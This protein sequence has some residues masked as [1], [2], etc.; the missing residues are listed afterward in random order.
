[1]IDISIVIVNYNVQHYLRQTLLS[2]RAAAGAL[3]LECFVVDNASSDDSVAMLKQAFPELNLIA[4]KENLGFSKGNNL[5]L[6][7]AKGKYILLLNP[8]TILTE[9]CLVKCRD[10]MDAHPEAGALGPKMI[11]GSGKFLPESK[12]GFPSPSVAFY[13]AFGLSKLFK[14]SPRFNRYHMGHVSTDETVPVDVLA[15]AF[16]FIRKEVLDKIGLLDERFFMYGEDID[17]SY[18]I[19]EAGY[20]NYYYPEA[21]IIHFKGE[22][23]K[24]GSMNYVRVFYQA[25]ILF[26][27]KHFKGKK[28][29]SFI[30][31]MKFGI[32]LR[33]LVDVVKAASYKI[34][35]PLFDFL[36]IF[37]GLYAFKEFWEVYYF[38]NPRHFD[39]TNI[40]YYMLAYTLV[41]MSGAYIFG[42]YQ[43][44]F[45]YTTV[46]QGI[47]LVSLIQFAVYGMLNPLYRPSRMM[48]V[49]GTV[50]AL[51][52]FLI[53][54]L[55]PHFIQHGNLDFGKDLKKKLLII[56]GREEGQRI[57]SLLRSARVDYD[58]LKR[59]SPDKTGE[60]DFLQ[61]VKDMIRM[62]RVD[63]IIWALND[64]PY[65]VMIDFMT[66]EGQGISHK[67]VDGASDVI[68]GSQSK[69]EQGEQY[70]HR[71]HFILSDP[72]ALRLKR[73][74]DLFVAVI[75]LILSPLLL[76]CKGNRWGL[77]RNIFRVF[78]GDSWVGY[79]PDAPD[80]SALPPLRRGVL[81]PVYSEV[82]ATPELQTLANL[83]YAKH[84][85]I[86]LDSTIL[87]KNRCR[88]G[89]G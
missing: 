80:I 59:I 69:N 84:Y 61:P 82:K 58:L 32:G 3:N 86:L 78:T 14:H 9:D 26:A 67:M 7:Q 17:M 39:G 45:R 2:V 6:R 65:K 47:L 48:L 36:F 68:L 34:W 77:Y 62:L 16:M 11:D 60:T 75:C 73:L 38:D 85:S 49:L 81:P 35:L 41:W 8:D 79:Y 54:R 76:L 42:G 5:A 83:Q 64:V 30:G 13:K 70:I 88:M 29:T 52:V 89:G 74:F 63:E 15:G 21:L 22:S 20:E 33:A 56:G 37:L 55:V 43:R 28:A 66:G 25:M 23:T 50:W 40:Y 27:D 1:M 19:K 18:R 57:Q 4:S 71:E 31:L 51:I 72:V 10:F 46:L 44:R 53:N 24:K 12:R 87:F